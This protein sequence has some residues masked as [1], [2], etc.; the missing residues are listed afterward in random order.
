LVRIIRVQL[1]Q[2]ADQI[3]GRR[4]FDTGGTRGDL[5]DPA[6]DT[7]VLQKPLEA[8]RFIPAESFIEGVT[9]RF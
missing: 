9:P 3:P 6:L 7:P 4:V 2:S 5:L 1:D 8:L